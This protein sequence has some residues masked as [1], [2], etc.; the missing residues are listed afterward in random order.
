[1]QAAARHCPERREMAQ[2]QVWTGGA[3]ARHRVLRHTTGACFFALVATCCVALLG[4]WG[5]ASAQSRPT[6]E[7]RIEVV[8]RK[9]FLSA[10][11]VELEPRFG[12][13]VNDALIR[14]FA[15]GGSLTYH[16]TEQLWFGGTFNWFDLGELGGVTDD[17]FVVLE[18][19]SAAPDLVEMSWYAGADVGFTP[20]YGKFALFNAGIIYYDVSVFAGGGWA[21]HTTGQTNGEVGAPAGS[22]GLQPRV[23]LS[24]WLAL[25]AQVRD[26]IFF[27]DVLGGSSLTQIVT[28][29]GGVSIYFPF[30]FD[31]TTAR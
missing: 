31:Y 24:D 30:T 3:S 26:T 14:Q 15:V 28:F 13:T 19:T 6:E 25:T 27:A 11:R 10:G 22:V 7:D 18:K 21:T 17:Y 5:E 2:S 23:F 16:A 29:S 12:S 9:P 4:A 8:Q 1:M 20:I